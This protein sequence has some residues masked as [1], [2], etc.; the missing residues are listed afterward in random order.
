MSEPAGPEPTPRLRPGARSEIGQRTLLVLLLPTLAAIWL[1]VFLDRAGR[2]DAGRSLL[3][4]H[5]LGQVV[6]A[7]WLVGALLTYTDTT[8]SYFRSTIGLSPFR[9]MIVLGV[10][11]VVTATTYVEPAPLFFAFMLTYMYGVGVEW[12]TARGLEQA[13]VKADAQSEARA[14]DDQTDA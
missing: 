14:A 10:L 12:W 5:V 7:T 2:I 11:G 9:F 4:G 1:A 13:T 3:I 6:T 8:N